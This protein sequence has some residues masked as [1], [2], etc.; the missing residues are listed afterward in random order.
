MTH[1]KRIS[2]ELTLSVGPFQCCLPVLNPLKVTIR[3]SL[4]GKVEHQT[5]ER[6]YT[7]WIDLLNHSIQLSSLRV[8]R[9]VGKFHIDQ[10]YSRISHYK[11]K[12]TF[13]S[14]LSFEVKLSLNRILILEYTTIYPNLLVEHLTLILL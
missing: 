14:K 10:R 7:S 5:R 6:L 11:S 1:D 9:C 13:T 12:T 3:L 2:L 8:R 4:K